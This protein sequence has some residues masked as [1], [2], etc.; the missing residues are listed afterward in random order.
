MVGV[1]VDKGQMRLGIEQRLM[2]VLTVQLDKASRQVPKRSSGG[3]RTV[4]EGSA[5]SLAGDLPADDDLAAT[6]LKNRFDGGVGLAGSNEV[7]RGAPAEQKPHGFHDDR[8]ARSGLAGENVEARLELDLDGLNHREVADA[9][10]A[11]HTS[12]TSIVSYV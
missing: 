6:V 11:E 10:K 4:D 5:A 9:Q 12:G 7:G 3:K 2:L 8:L 1:F